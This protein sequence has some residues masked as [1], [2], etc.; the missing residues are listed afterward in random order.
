LEWFIKVALLVFPSEWEQKEPSRICPPPLPASPHSTLPVRL[1]SREIRLHHGDI[2][3]SHGGV[4][5]ESTFSAAT[6]MVFLSYLA[7]LLIPCSHV[8]FVLSL[9]CMVKYASAFVMLLS[10]IKFTQKMPNILTV[11]AGD[12]SVGP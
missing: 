2:N 10:V 7:L 11:H 5:A 12:H 3:D 1:F 8:M 6:Y 4:A 9:M